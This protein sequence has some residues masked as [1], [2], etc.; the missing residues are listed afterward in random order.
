MT[1]LFQL[2]VLLY[3]TQE[4]RLAGNA[5]VL[6]RTDRWSGVL[7]TVILEGKVEDEFESV[8]NEL[9]DWFREIFRQETM[10]S[11]N[12]DEGGLGCHNKTW[13]ARWLKQQTFISLKIWRLE[14]HNHGAS[15]FGF[16]YEHSSWLA[17]GHHLTVLTWPSCL[18]VCGGGIEGRGRKHSFLMSLL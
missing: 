17:H 15:E 8:E 7:G 13:Q 12:T 5:C 18:G 14:V 10:R 3:C 4:L 2:R 11:W 1:H 9:S 6:M 16:W